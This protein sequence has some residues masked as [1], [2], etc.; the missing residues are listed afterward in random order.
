[1]SMAVEEVLSLTSCCCRWM[2]ALDV[3]ANVSK[4]VFIRGDESVDLAEKKFGII[5]EGWIGQVSIELESEC[6]AHAYAATFLVRTI[7]PGSAS[8][9]SP[10]SNCSRSDFAG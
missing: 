1:M 10:A 6:S 4:S 8:K 7:Y 9:I 2:K 5:Q 3:E